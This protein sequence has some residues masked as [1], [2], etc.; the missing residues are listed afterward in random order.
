MPAKARTSPSKL[1]FKMVTTYRNS[2]ASIRRLKAR[3]LLQ[4]SRSNQHG[5]QSAPEAAPQPRRFTW[6]VFASLS[7]LL[8]VAL[9]LLAFV[10]LNRKSR[11]AATR[12]S[13]ISAP[14]GTM[15]PENGL[16]ILCGHSGS[17]YRDKQGNLW[18]ADA[19]FSGGT[20][21]DLGSQPIYRTSDSFLFRAARSGEFSYRIPLKPGVYEMRLYFADTNYSLGPAMEGGEN[22]RVFNVLLNGEPALRNFD[23][24]NEAGPNTADVRVFKDVQPASDGYLHLAT[25]R[26]TDLP[27]L[28][29]IEIVP[30]IP[31][32]L[33]PIRIVTQENT[34]TDRTGGVWSPDNFFLG[35]RT[36][37]RFG[38]VVGPDDP[39][40]YERERYGN[41]SYAIPVATGRYSVTLH[42]AETYWGPKS[43]G[44]GGAGNRIFD[45][46]CNGTTLTEEFRHVQ[47]GR[48]ASPTDQK[49]PWAAAECPRHPAF[50]FYSRSQLRKSFGHRS[51]G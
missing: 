30:G 35:G 29:A 32:H 6:A 45:V 7:V 25:S 41:F 49:L 46:Y 13:D 21:V 12:A 1:S 11:L 47:R 20:A 3:I 31:H 15:S 22:V 16:R 4:N 44:G 43:Q 14:L 36:I 42:F 2:S 8:V 50:P 37:A 17:G 34:L 10:S 28:N 26:L 48:L 9:A 27:L 40:V 24:I 18:G 39:Q 5:N 51:I 38:T 19:F 23:I 33:R